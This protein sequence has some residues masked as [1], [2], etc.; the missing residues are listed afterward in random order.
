[1][2]II[3]LCKRFHVR[4]LWVFGSVLTNRFHKD[5]DVDLCVDFDK[6]KIDIF[7]YADNFFDF[8]YAMEDLFGRKVD[9]TED[10]A[11]RNPYFRAELNKTRQLIYG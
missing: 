7:D 10:A 1:Q 8:Q 6:E 11:V 3:E 9:I 2:N 4:K 5:S